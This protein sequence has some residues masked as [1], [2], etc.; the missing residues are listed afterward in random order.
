MHSQCSFFEKGYTGFGNRFIK[1]K[2]PMNSLTGFDLRLT[3][4]QIGAYTTGQPLASQ[5]ITYL[6]LNDLTITQ[7]QSVCQSVHH[8]RCN[9]GQNTSLYYP[10]CRIVHIKDPLLLIEKS[11]S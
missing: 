6:F 4:H 1:K 7:D 3:V 10:V 9:E 11:S 5:E 8:K 2:Q